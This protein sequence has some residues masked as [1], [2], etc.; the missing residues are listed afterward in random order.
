[1]RHKER[2]GLDAGDVGDRDDHAPAGRRHLPVRR[3]GGE[4]EPLGRRVERR[5]EELLGHVLRPHGLEP[6][7]W[8]VDDDVEAAQLDRRGVDQRRHLGGVAGLR[9]ERLGVDAE[10]LDLRAGGLGRMGAR[11]VADRDV[12]AG[13]REVEGD[14]LAQPVRTPDHEA[15]AA[16]EGG[17]GGIC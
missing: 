13:L 15:S 6:G 1:M 2:P 5:V 9:R 17:H 4:H 16:V 10:C 12:G 7:R 3:L 8:A 14:R 11:V